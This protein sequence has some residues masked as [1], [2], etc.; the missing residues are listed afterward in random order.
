MCLYL[1]N[2]AEL[3]DPIRHI[4]YKADRDWNLKNGEVITITAVMDEK[5]LQKGYLLTRSETTITIEGF[6]RYVSTA[7]DLT[8]DVLRRISDR[9][10]QECVSGGSVDL[11]DGSSNMTPWGAAISDIR[12]GDTA[13]L[14]VN[15]QTDMEY[16]FLLVP[17]Y[18]TITTH[19][20]YDMAANANV[21]K[22]WENVMGYYKFTDV[23]V[24]PDGTVTFNE[25]YV[26]QNG[27]YTDA[28][29]ADGLYLNQF[30]SGYTL[31]EI[32]MT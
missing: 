31:T 10:Y 13:L 25:S 2:N 22:T 23:T 9:A 29:A 7:S 32:P 17:V 18:K 15:N 27:C 1:R 19:E 3:S 12:V 4:T 8:G 6:D 21:T 20:W 30:R 11:Y 14:A 5:F 28:N 26:E 16:S 24:H